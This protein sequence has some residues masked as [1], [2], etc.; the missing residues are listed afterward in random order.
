MGENYFEEN[1]P[2]PLTMHKMSK[3][4]MKQYKNELKGWVFSFNK[5]THKLKLLSFISPSDSTS[6]KSLSCFFDFRCVIH[7]AMS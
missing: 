3:T 6:A 7:E 1:I 5:I 4:V 2:R